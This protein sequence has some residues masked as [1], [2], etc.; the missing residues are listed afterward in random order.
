MLFF[1]MV[2]KEVLIA[3]VAVAFLNLIIRINVVVVITKSSRQTTVFRLFFDPV[4]G[5]WF[6]GN[7]NTKKTNIKCRIH[8]RS[9]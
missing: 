6:K 1:S 9:L 3:V 8:I 4:H 2:Y 5:Q 7:L